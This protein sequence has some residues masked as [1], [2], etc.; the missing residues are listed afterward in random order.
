LVLAAQLEPELEL[1]LALA[2]SISTDPAA[3]GPAVP[4]GD[5]PVCFPARPEPVQAARWRKLKQGYAS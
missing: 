2:R 1:L 3:L 5:A 4:S